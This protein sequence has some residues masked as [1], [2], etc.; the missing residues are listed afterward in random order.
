MDVILWGRRNVVVQHTFNSGDVQ[1]TTSIQSMSKNTNK[2]ENKKMKMKT[3]N[4][5][6]P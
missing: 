3:K 6:Q 2:N 4:E 1:T 5:T